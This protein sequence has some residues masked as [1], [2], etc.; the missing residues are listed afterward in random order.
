MQ[1][2]IE[3]Y[4]M[5]SKGDRVVCG[6]SGGADSVA[7]LRGLVDL[8]ECFEFELCVAHLNHMLRGNEAE[9][10]ADFVKKLCNELNV[11]FYYKAVD[12][13][14][15]AKE[16]GESVELAARNARYAFFEDV[17]KSFGSNKIATAH[18]ANDNF[19]TMLMHLARGAGLNGM[20]GIPPIR[21]NI[22][23][24]L[25]ETSREQVVSYLHS[26]DQKYV[27]DSTNS[28]PIYTRNHVR[29]DVIPLLKE[30][31]PKIIESSVRSSQMFRDDEACL[32][33]LANELSA[34]LIKN[35]ENNK[36]I[37]SVTE[38]SAYPIALQRRIILSLARRI[39]KF[40]NFYLEFEH[41][42]DII[43]VMHSEKASLKINLPSGLCVAKS[44]DNL[45]FMLSG[46]AEKSLE[47][48][49]LSPGQE[50]EFGDYIVSCEKVR[51]SD[52]KRT[53][54]SSFLISSEKEIRGIVVRSRRIG[55]E[56]KL[57]GRPRKTLKKLF[58]ENRIPKE[59]RD[60]IPVV[61]IDDEIAAVYGIGVNEKFKS[62]KSCNIYYIEIRGK[63]R[64]E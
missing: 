33:G 24:P 20:C 38:L 60:R 17:S 4:N 41:I 40:T 44:Y 23:R 25:I 7:M 42:C 50:K 46:N 12:I 11:E 28:K 8:R 57:V 2:T 34:K 5:L 22:I 51:G 61:C 45:V 10:D 62:I 53:D 32:N 21:N 48:V 1:G 43:N 36:I 15:L 29:L 55:D 18:N 49:Y 3:K 47:D 27:E 16:R 58:I 19:E 56:I 13:N 14:A 64:Y 63:N 54:K 59:D 30:I 6:V 39:I 52:K 26:T 31:N 9:R 35:E 37:V